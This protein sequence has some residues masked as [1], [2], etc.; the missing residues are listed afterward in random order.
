MKYKR[1]SSPASARTSRLW[2]YKNWVYDS[3]LDKGYN[4][5]WIWVYTEIGHEV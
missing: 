5:K 4:M 1:M 3:L 2:S